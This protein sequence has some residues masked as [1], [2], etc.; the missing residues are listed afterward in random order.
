M[1][2]MG[3]VAVCPPLAVSRPGYPDFFQLEYALML[4]NQTPE[5]APQPEQPW[6][7]QPGDPDL[8]APGDP[9]T[10]QPEFPPPY[11]VVAVRKPLW[12]R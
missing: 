11:V 3:R 4:P 12:G 6:P 2:G 9:R 8:P 10:P 7:P 5:P 1:I